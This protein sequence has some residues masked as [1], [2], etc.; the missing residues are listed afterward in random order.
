MNI[1]GYRFG[2]IDIEGRPYKWDL[3]IT[4]ERVIE[5]WSRRQSHRVAAADLAEVVAAKPDVVVVGTGCYGRM[6][7]SAEARHYLETQGIQVRDAPTHQAVND[8]N[9]L[10]AKHARVVAA[11]HLTC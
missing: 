1:T 7:V 8:F 9:Q 10:Q 3:I 2:R 11:L 6:A 5:T 4:P